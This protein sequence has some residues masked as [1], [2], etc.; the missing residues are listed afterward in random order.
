MKKKLLFVISQL[1][2]GGAEISL[3]NLLNSLNYNLYDVDLV[4]LN[5]EPVNDAVSLIDKVNSH[6]NICNAYKEYQNINILDRIHAKLIYSMEEK[7]A[8]Y[9]TALDFVRNNLYDWAFFVGEW[10][11]PSFVANHVEATVKAAWIHSDISRAHYFDAD[12]YFYF[13]D[14]FD[15]F[16]FV[17][18]TS[19][20][21]SIKAFPFLKE[22]AVTIYNITDIKDIKSKSMETLDF[23]YDKT[24]PMLLTC[25]NFRKEK[26]HLRQVM[27]M[28]ELKK[29]GI[30]F[31]WVNVGATA[32]SSL[33]N[34]VKE[35]CA[36]ENIE[37]N[38]IILGP[39][40]NPYSYMRLADAVTVLSDHESWSM[41]ITEAKVI[42]TPVIATKTSG[43]IEQIEHKKTGILTDF[44][45]NDIADKIEEFINV[46]NLQHKIRD[47]I[48]N[49]DN[50]DEILESFYKLINK[51]LPIKDSAK[52]KEESILYVVDNINYIGGAHGATKLQIQELLKINKN[53]TIFSTTIPNL[54][55]RKELEGA[56][57]LALDSIR[58]DKIYNKRVF[59]CISNR[60]VN[61][62]EKMSRI[63]QFFRQRLFHDSTYYESYVLLSVSDLFSDFN[64][65][66]ITSESSSFR[67]VLAKSKCKNKIQWI[68]T[69][70]CAWRQ[71]NE[72][73]ISIT[74]DDGNIYNEFNL[75]VLLSE[76]IKTKFDKLYPYL[77]NKT[78]V[79][80][81]LI[82]TNTILSKANMIDLDCSPVHF[83]T[84]GRLGSEK[85]FSRLFKILYRLKENG[86]NFRW[87]IIGDGDEESHLAELIKRLDLSDYVTLFGFK[88][89]PYKLM[90]KA[91]V[92]ALLSN[93]EGIPNT[94]YEALILGIPVLATN[95]G[96]ISDQITNGVN[97]WLAENNEEDIY[98]SIKY[99]IENKAEI[100][101]IKRNLELYSYDN[102]SVLRSLNNIF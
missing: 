29:R 27:V 49:Y 96:G 57:F 31:I 47:N 58:T 77:K 67:K 38:F 56:H 71:F 5:Q 18:E 48:R 80:K 10:Y 9:I 46:K 33:V 65:V 43:A 78:V 6:V 63:K 73:T 44:D 86:Y 12:H 8:Y 59:D 22:K 89:N 2:K 60:T 102:E 99:L 42:G 68:H 14:K 84:V 66:C 24:K 13:Y 88:S 17:S 50:T 51:Q 62:H 36:K 4:V 81:N 52:G 45:V 16:I 37:S 75:I 100:E 69:D 25:A 87:D 32:D 23:V 40:D 7:G 34:D 53:I 1:Y 39:K 54:M 101:K 93:Y 19:L 3:V 21:S 55:V 61:R 98:T 91:Q 30:D 97:G 85:A 83:M 70:Y 92:F 26:N 79:V 28:S 90:K 95:V 72:W 64:T 74:K 35:L 82:S 76:N 15:Y 20:R 94:I 41:V 11:S